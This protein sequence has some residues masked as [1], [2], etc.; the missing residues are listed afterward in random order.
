MNKLLMKLKEN[1]P[2]Q[3]TWLQIG[4]PISAGVVASGGFDWV[5]VDLEHGIIGIETMANMF[6]AIE[7][8]G[9]VPVA[10]V[11]SDDPTFIHR[12]L[13]AGAQGIIVPMVMC[14]DQ[15][16][17]AVRFSKYPPEGY[18]GYGYCRANNY[19]EQFE[20]YSQYANNEIAIIAQIEHHIAIDNLWPIL[21]TEGL[22]ATFIGPYDLSGSLGCPGDF[23][24]EKYLDAIEKYL[25][26]SKQAG[27]PTGIHI[28][29]TN[30]ENVE[31]AVRLGYSMIALGMDSRFLID[32]AKYNSDMFFDIVENYKEE[33][34]S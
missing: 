6:M 18:R 28:V 3:G 5:C 31:N 20:M 33:K 4:N 34:K 25:L 8:C 29:H 17:D 30:H 24:N 9:A 2:T 27:V 16:R 32:G 15:C 23:K 11:P 1:K 21:Q 7:S 22:D 13:D 14:D 12:V 19:G 26:M 10:R